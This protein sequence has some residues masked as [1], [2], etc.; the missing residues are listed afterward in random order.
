[1]TDVKMKENI[2]SIKDDIKNYIK[3]ISKDEEKQNKFLEKSM[4]QLDELNPSDPFDK[5]KFN[6]LKSNVLG[7]NTKLKDIA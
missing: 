4:N 3:E 7:A 2:D 1:M 6:A 5:L